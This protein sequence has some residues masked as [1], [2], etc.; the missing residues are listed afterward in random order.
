MTPL[1]D[2]PVFPARR[3]RIA[4]IGLAS[5]DRVI[6]VDRYPEVGRF[7]VVRQ[8]LDG[9][10]GTTTNAVAALAKLGAEVSIRALVG[11]DDQGR[12]LR[13]AME[14]TG[15]NVDWLTVTEGQ[16]TDGATVIVSHDPPDRTIYWHQ[17]ARLVRGDRIDIPALFAH[18]VVLVDVDDPPLRR[19]L[20]DL[21]AHTLPAARLLGSLTYLDD[22]GIPDAFDLM[23][24]HDVIVG[25]RRELISITEAA[26]LD[27]AIERVRARMRGEN[28]R[29]GVVSLG[30]EGAV[31]FTFDCRWDY[32]AYPVCIVDTTGAGDA[33]AGAVAFGMACR[34]AWPMVLRFANAVAGLSVTALGAQTALPSWDA[35]NALMRDTAAI[36][37]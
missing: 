33:F 29:A 16:P 12:Q 19:F 8:E 25:N 9:P 21:P 31:A 35:A 27:G 34:W 22:A 23:M 17:G 2:L 18:D 32:P 5:W 15:A 20:V 28:L 3:P 37:P 7:A 30:A 14:A 4:A 13:A 11:E 6:V 26:D 10:G 24:R 1:D 36:R